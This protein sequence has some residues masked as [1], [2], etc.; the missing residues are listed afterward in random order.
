[1]SVLL[2]GGAGFLGSHLAE[3][4]VSEGKEITILDDM[5]RGSLENLSAIEDQGDVSIRTIDLLK[6]DQL[7]ELVGKHE[8]V[9]H[10]AAKIGGVGYLRD[11]PADIIA[12]N[13]L[14]NRRVF[15]ACAYADIDRL[16]YASS[17]MV[18]AEA[19]TFPTPESVVEDIPPPKGS[20]GFQKL[21]GEYYCESYQRQ[22]DLEYVSAR[23]FNAVGPRDWP[24]EQVGHGH[25]VPDLVKKIVELEQ[26]PIPVKGSGRQSRC[27]TD[28][29]D[30]V[31]GLHACMETP[32]ARNEVFN[33]S[34]TRETTI[35]ELVTSI[36]NA[37]GR[38]GQPD[39]ETHTAFE[40]DVQRRVPDISKAE[41]ILGW[42]PQYSLEEA[43]KWYIDAFKEY[44]NGA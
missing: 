26:N 31:R 28:V 39:I 6:S 24:E 25:V 16:L 34:R 12:D 43:L 18:Y 17:S 20:Y 11:R 36:W 15:E 8:Q 2:T 10:L 19:S 3:H 30:T 4:L 9:Y 35:R 32:D 42:T 1:M 37:A 38:S 13:D 23:I 5:S 41:S 7:V 33:I 22:Y 40:K 21:N 44:T 27:F 14:M 29:R